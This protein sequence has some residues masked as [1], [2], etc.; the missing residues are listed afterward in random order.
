MPDAGSPA[1]RGWYLPDVACTGQPASAPY[2]EQRMD[3]RRCLEVLGQLSGEAATSA[4]T[5]RPTG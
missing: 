1:L 2:L 3:A 4:A 5:I